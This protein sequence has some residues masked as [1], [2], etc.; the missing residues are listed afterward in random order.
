MFYGRVV[1]RNRKKQFSYGPS[2]ARS[3]PE[4]RTGMN[5]TRIFALMALIVG[6]NFFGKAQDPE[7]S[8]FYANPLYLNPALAG[9]ED[10]NRAIIN[11]RNQWPELDR[12]FVTYNASYDQFVNKMHGGVG[13]LL[14]YDN[15]GQ[16]MLNTIQASL[17]YAYTLTVSSNLFINGAMQVKL[18]QRSLNWNM[19]RF[20]DQIDL[21]QVA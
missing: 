16:G 10:Y 3:S 8:Q 17:I 5:C 21:L 12:G 1:R 2:G 19:L 20:G 18:Y 7:F 9:S 11:Y 15:A 13:A 4:K 14:N 6:F